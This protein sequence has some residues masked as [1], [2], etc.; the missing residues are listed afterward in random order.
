M[1]LNVRV[2]AA[3]PTPLPAN[4]PPSPQP[5][6]R[7]SRTRTIL[8]PLVAMALVA[9]AI[10]VVALLNRVGRTDGVLAEAGTVR[11]AATPSP[12]TV[13]LPL[14]ADVR[15]LAVEA[16]VA[17]PPAA[18]FAGVGCWTEAGIGY[19]VG[20]RADGATGI[21]RIDPTGTIT[22]LTAL[23]SA[24][25]FRPGEAQRLRLECVPGSGG[26]DGGILA[27]GYVNGVPAVTLAIP[28]GVETF[29]AAG[30]SAWMT[31][32]DSTV[33]MEDV[34]ATRQ[35]ADSG[36]PPMIESRTMPPPSWAPTP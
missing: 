29:T 27:T 30:V 4:P 32:A 1:S 34:V 36:P 20:M 3:G 6:Q 28:G 16:T 10:G 5:P 26:T 19:V 21:A 22:P 7:R 2:R 24:E 25:A 14:A 12:G 9:A 31:P 15:G 18:G 11:I 23:R 35:R 33:E 13:T 17:S 8:V